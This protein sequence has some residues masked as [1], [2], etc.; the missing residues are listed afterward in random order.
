LHRLQVV[1]QSAYRLPGLVQRRDDRCRDRT[2]AGARDPL[3]PV[4][5]LIEGKDGAGQADALHPAAL[6]DQIGRL[7][8]A[9]HGCRRRI[10]HR[11]LDSL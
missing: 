8:G 10:G 6:Q 9:P 7:S 3:K 2:G 5:G 11:S 1:P 4:P